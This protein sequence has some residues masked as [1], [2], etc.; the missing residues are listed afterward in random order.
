[1][2]GQGTTIS[3]HFPRAVLEVDGDAAPVDDS[4]SLEGCVLLVEDNDAVATVT[5]SLLR[6][7]GLRVSRV[8]SADAALTRLAGE[9]L[10]DIVF[11]DISMPG[12]IDGI[13]LAFAIRERWPRL[14]VVLTTGYAERIDEAVAAGFKVMP[15]PA[16]PDEVLAE[17]SNALEMQSERG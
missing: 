4:Q 9:E 14:P 5:E 3:M 12:S 16:S 1:M 10:P 13:G 17:I 7:A 6:A 15:K 2:V 11:S 8:M